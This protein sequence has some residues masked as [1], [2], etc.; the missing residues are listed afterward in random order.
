MTD[1]DALR[2]E[3]A[4][5]QRRLAILREQAAIAGRNAD[6][7]VLLEIQDI[8]ARVDVIERQLAGQ[9]A[10]QPDAAPADWLRGLP[11]AAGDVIVA[12]IGPGARQVAVG[13]D[14]RQGDAPGPADAD[15]LA[16][17]FDQLEA[18]LA[19]LRPQLGS[20]AEM[21]AFQLRLLRGELTKDESST[22]SAAAITAVGGWLLANVPQLAGALAALL[23]APAARRA[24]ARAGPEAVAWAD[25]TSG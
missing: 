9:P 24:L 17:R 6:P 15:D 4:A 2:A 18:A 1:P 23:A 3:L 22:P 19:A 12:N 25:R 21:A 20:A 5:H 11:G 13:K 7:A 16:A 14:I 10:P 8:T